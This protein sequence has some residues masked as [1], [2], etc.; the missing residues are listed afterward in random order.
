MFYHK[1]TVNRSGLKRHFK[2][3]NKPSKFQKII[4]GTRWVTH[5]KV[6][7][8]TMIDTLQASENNLNQVNM[9][10]YN[11]CFFLIMKK[12]LAIY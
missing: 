10:N 1:S 9:T 3:L 6:A 12:K 4:G 2:Q 7:V 5:T 8:E 11:F